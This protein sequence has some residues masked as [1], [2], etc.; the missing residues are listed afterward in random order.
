MGCVPFPQILIFFCT[1]LKKLIDHYGNGESGGLQGLEIA[2]R[3]TSPDTGKPMEFVDLN[4][5]GTI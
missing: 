1:D 4:N 3:F 2:P 5:Q